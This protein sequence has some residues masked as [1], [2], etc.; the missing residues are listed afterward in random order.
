MGLNI[1]NYLL[2]IDH[3]SKVWMYLRVNYTV[4]KSSACFQRFKVFF[5]NC[6]LYNYGIIFRIQGDKKSF[7][8]IRSHLGL[9]HSTFSIALSYGETTKKK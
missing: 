8:K 1:Y 6:Y 3:F 5:E 4:V 9:N 7:V 2:N